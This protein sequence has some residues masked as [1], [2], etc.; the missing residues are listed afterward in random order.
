MEWE[1]EKEWRII[2][3]EDKH[4]ESFNSKLVTPKSIIL[5][6]RISVED[7]ELIVDIAKSK[8]IPLKQVQLDRTKY[9]LLVNELLI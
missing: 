7:K 3:F 5:G 9:G 2:L 6:S 1:Y 8:N 4:N